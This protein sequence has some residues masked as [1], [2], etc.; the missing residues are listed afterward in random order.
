M[1]GNKGR[2]CVTGGTGYI[3]SWT[4][5]RLLE[6]GYSVNTTIRSNSEHKKDLSFLTSL[7]GAS[8]NLQIFN[9]DLENPETFVAAIEGATAVVFNGKDI[10]VMDESFLSD[11][12]YIRSLNSTGDSYFICK[13]LTEKSALE[14]AEQHGLD[15]VT[16]IPSYVLGPFICPKLPGSVHITLAMV[17]GDKDLYRYL[18]NATVVHV[19][20]FARAH[21]FLLEHS[22]PKGR[23]NCSSDVLTIE[24]MS[25]FLS[26]KYP[27]QFPVPTV[28][29]VKEIKGRKTPSLSSKKLLDAGFK[30]NNPSPP[31][32]YDLPCFG[33]G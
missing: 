4:I 18:I 2:V 27:N 8:Q 3:G 17:F 14:F 15:L 7:P 12:D 31:L 22:N 10:E 33:Y 13:T 6:N 28:E 9:A 21:I 5:K 24:G 1:E 29:C 20:D 25:E 16:V 11:V 23:Y 26:S 19:D 32:S 30:F